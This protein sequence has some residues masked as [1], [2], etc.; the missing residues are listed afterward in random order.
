MTVLQY[1]QSTQ[2]S[3]IKIIIYIIFSVVKCCFNCNKAVLFIL[4]VRA[5]RQ[6]R[7]P[8]KVI[9]NDGRY[10]CQLNV[11]HI[12]QTAN[13]AL[14]LYRPSI[15]HINLLNQIK[16]KG[17]P[18]KKVKCLAQSNHPERAKAGI[19]EQGM[20]K[21]PMGCEK[22]LY[23]IYNYHAIHTPLELYWF[24]RLQMF[25]ENSFLYSDWARPVSIMDRASRQLP[26]ACACTGARTRCQIW[27]PDKNRLIQLKYMQKDH[28][29]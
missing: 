14:V 2:K 18:A 27:A 24:V 12:I 15:F 7:P 26:K 19:L 3:L 20:R 11:Q 28:G 22:T 4:T 1:R 23:I 13:V 5:E 29:M 17:L 6:T 10:F 25:T 8:M 9:G 21:K 16:V